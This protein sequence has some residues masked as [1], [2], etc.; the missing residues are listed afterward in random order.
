MHEWLEAR[1]DLLAPDLSV[2]RYRRV[3]RAL[4]GYHAALE[5]G[6]MRIAAMALAAAPRPSS[7]L[8][9]RDLLALGIDRE[10]IA[11]VPRC[12]ALPPLQ[13]VEHLAGCVY[14]TEGAKLGGRVIARSVER[15]LGFTSERGCSY[16]SNEGKD[17]RPGWAAVT[18]WID[19]LGATVDGQEV[20]RSATLTFE[21]LAD[22]LASR[23]ALG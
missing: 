10:E 6:L 21:T 9:E 7:P 22:W 19:D 4:Y 23:G 20:V 2:D 13:T 1:L 12:A 14:V 5:P 16:F 3:L 15:R 18:G 11:G 8:L 17:P